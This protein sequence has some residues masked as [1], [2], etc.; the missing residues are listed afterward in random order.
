MLKDPVIMSDKS[1][2][3]DKFRKIIKNNISYIDKESN[4]EKE[5]INVT[6]EI[7]FIK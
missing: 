5:N 7:Y 3:K 6:N 2:W 1:K 4:P